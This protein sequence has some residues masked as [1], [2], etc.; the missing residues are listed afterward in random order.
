MFLKPSIFLATQKAEEHTNEKPKA[1]LRFLN[2]RQDQREDG[3]HEISL[4]LRCLPKYL[5][6]FKNKVGWTIVS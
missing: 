3:T 4:F 2:Q 6:D 1:V 5:V